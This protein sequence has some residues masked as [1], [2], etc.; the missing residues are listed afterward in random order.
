MGAAEEEQMETDR[1]ELIN[2]DQVRT[3]Q[4]LAKMINS[5][6][7]PLEIKKEIIAEENLQYMD[8]ETDSGDVEYIRMVCQDS[9]DESGYDRNAIADESILDASRDEDEQDDNSQDEE[10]E[11]G[12]DVVTGEESDG[13][14][15]DYENKIPDPSQTNN[16][17]EVTG[18][19]GALLPDVEGVEQQERTADLV[20]PPGI[21]EEEAENRKEDKEK[22]I[23]DSEDESSEVPEILDPRDKNLRPDHRYFAVKALLPGSTKPTKLNPNIKDGPQDAGFLTD[24][25]ERW[26]RNANVSNIDKR[27]NSSA[28]FTPDGTCHTCLSGKHAAWIG[29]DKQPIVVA[30]SDQHFPA[31]L[32]ADG[33]GDCIRILR[34]ENGSLRE[35][36]SELIRMVPSSG[37]CPGSVVLLGAPAQLGVVSAEAY[38]ADWK[39]CRNWLKNDLGEIIVLPLMPV[40]A[41]GISDRKI[42]RSIIDLSAWLESLP[43]PELKLIRNTRLQ[44]FD[45]NLGKTVRGPGWA[46]TELNMRFPVSLSAESKGL[47]DFLVGNWGTR[48]LQI[49]PMTEAGEK[50]WMDKLIGELNRELKSGLAT[51]VCYGRTLSAVKRQDEC[52]G[53][54]NVVTI[55]AS[56]ARR[57]AA[58]LRRKGVLV[59]EM[60]RPGWTITPTSVEAMVEEIIFEDKTK[61]VVVLQC[62][63]N[64]VFFVVDELG[65]LAAPVKDKNGEVHIVG[66]VQVARDLQ[67]EILLDQLDPLLLSRKEELTLLVCPSCRFLLSCCDSHDRKEEDGNRMLRELGT[68]RREL[69]TRLI[70]KG[71][72]N[73]ILVDPL[74][75]NGAARSIEVA[76]SLMKDMFHMKVAGFSRLAE[77]IKEAIHNWLLGRKR[78][79][80]GRAGPENKRIRLDAKPAAAAAG[81][82]GKK[83]GGR[84]GGGKGK[85]LAR[86]TAGE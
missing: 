34:I 67:L 55:G 74:E 25:D 50:Y 59:H 71:Y 46:D 35:I 61:D 5:A 33:P 24:G 14:N 27:L 41:N 39:F 17:V 10:E 38:A 72:S 69:K 54:F 40:S 6:A 9:E 56:N 11:D 77:A 53:A 68:L 51:S 30:A 66:R 63:D 29:K 64:R 15:P 8:Q 21:Q 37:L 7:D 43:D 48:P 57:T 4:D 45:I 85:N 49:L 28:S 75:A 22:D 65:S 79:A 13:E 76:R 73:V 26:F 16:L 47:S 36:T 12:E 83:G 82:G 32:P 31:N 42:I 19:I 2:M 60:G 84:G 86:K 81:Q 23:P 3:R 58:A 18:G 78:K 20:N 44:F 62:L 80:E 1:E 70:N 52:V